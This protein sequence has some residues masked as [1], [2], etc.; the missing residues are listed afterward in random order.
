MLVQDECFGVHSSLKLVYMRERDVAFR[1]LAVNNQPNF[2]T[3]IDFRKDYHEAFT[4]LFVAIVQLCKAAGML[5]L[6]DVAL[7]S[8][9][10][11]RE[12]VLVANRTRDQIEDEI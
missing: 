2:R 9:R 11:Q 1:F 4:Q 6:S 10:V 5:D 7:D 3:V 12:S 8:R